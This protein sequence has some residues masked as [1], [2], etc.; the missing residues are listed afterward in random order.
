MDGKVGNYLTG[1]D[2]ITT[3]R[4]DKS[5][6]RIES[7]CFAGA[8]WT[9]KTDYRPGLDL[10]A[11]PVDNRSGTVTFNDI[12]SFEYRHRFFASLFFCAS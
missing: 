7:C 9:Q 4:A 1:K 5:S 11:D 12:S 8:V 6:N 10:K 2:D 3:V